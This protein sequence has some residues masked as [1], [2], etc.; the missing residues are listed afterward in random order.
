MWLG[1][2]ICSMRTIFGATNKHILLAEYRVQRSCVHRVCM[3]VC[4]HNIC[5]YYTTIFCVCMHSTYM[6]IHVH[7]VQSH[8]KQKEH[9]FVKL[10]I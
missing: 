9:Y 1:P 4:T 6:Y 7:T 2:Y 5:I 8:F 10:R 3:Y